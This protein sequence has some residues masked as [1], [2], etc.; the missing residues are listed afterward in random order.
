MIEHGP[1]VDEALALEHGL[2]ADEYK[3]LCDGLGRVPS[4]TELGVVSV[5]WSEH[6]SYKSSRM[7]L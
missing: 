7:H 3:L 5:M 1:S 6:C 4:Y 2:A